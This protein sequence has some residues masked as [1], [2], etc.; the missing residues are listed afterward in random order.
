MQNQR[1]DQIQC[2]VCDT[3]NNGRQAE[4]HFAVVEDDDEPDD[5]HSDQRRNARQTA[6]QIGKTC[7]R[8]ERD[9]RPWSPRRKPAA[10]PE[11]QHR[12]ESEGRM[13]P[14][15]QNADGEDAVGSV[16]YNRVCQ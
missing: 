9:S 2:D 1:I 16:Q 10:D 3:Q 4:N 13:P 11:V 14:V 7:F 12:A 15:H 8:T 6:P 5:L